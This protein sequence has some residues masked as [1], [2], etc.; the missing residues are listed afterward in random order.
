MNG[1]RRIACA[2]VGPQHREVIACYFGFGQPAH[3]T[4]VLVSLK[5]RKKKA[6]ISSPRSLRVSS[7]I[8]IF[9][10]TALVPGECGNTC[11]IDRVD[12]GVGGG[13]YHSAGVCS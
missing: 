5:G 9:V 7:F 6:C 8:P 4:S 3:P 13:E 10:S 11:V 1:G 2:S 12:P